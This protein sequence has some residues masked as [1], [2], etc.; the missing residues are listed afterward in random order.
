MRPG[1]EPVRNSPIEAVLL[2]NADL[3]HALG[4]L[5]L[6][7]AART[8]IV[9][10]R[11]DTR[12]QLSWIEPVLERFSRIEWREPSHS[13]SDLNKGIKYRRIDLPT[14]IAFA[15][16][17]CGNNHSVVIAPAVSEVTDELA[18]VMRQAEITFFDG[19]FWS[20]NELQSFRPNARISS[21]MGHVPV[22]QSLPLLSQCP[23]RKVYVHVNNTNPILAVDSTERRQVEH[24]GVEIG[25][26]G[27]EFE[28]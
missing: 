5:L 2:S 19:T 10:A 14:S 26:D 17:D 8:Q 20:E 1:N 18:S 28:L 24:A 11:G 3:D 4:L 13:F 23:G 15:F 7:Q 22:E 6:R 25:H 12:E 27:M 16:Y 21:Q 9:Y